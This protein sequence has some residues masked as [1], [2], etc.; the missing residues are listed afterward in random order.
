MEQ[1]Q[2]QEGNGNHSCKT[3]CGHRSHHWLAKIII[4]VL[5]F[6]A[7]YCFGVFKTVLKYRVFGYYDQ[8]RF[9]NMK[10]LPP[11]NNS[12]GWMMYR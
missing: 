9:W 12:Q 11:Q 10:T 7:G 5:V 8:E 1:T 3:I 4:L 6:S 2:N